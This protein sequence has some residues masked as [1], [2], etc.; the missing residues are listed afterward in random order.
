MSSYPIYLIE[1]ARIADDADDL[2]DGSLQVPINKNQF[3][4]SF[5]V[6]AVY[7]GS[8]PNG[9]ADVG[10]ELG[11]NFFRVKAGR[12]CRIRDGSRIRL[13]HPIYQ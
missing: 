10:I 3:G 4:D 11:P 9:V 5:L 13:V 2:W 8:T 6:T 1:A 12:I 7:T